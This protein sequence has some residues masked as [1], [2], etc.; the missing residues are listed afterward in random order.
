MQTISE[1]NAFQCNSCQFKQ[2]ALCAVLVC[3]LVFFHSDTRAH[4]EDEKV[5]F[6]ATTGQDLKRCNNR[7]R[8]C[9]SISYAAQ[10][11]NKGDKIL[12]AG[13]SY[14]ITSAEE[15]VYLVSDLQPVYGGYSAID[16]YQSQAPDKFVTSISGVPLAYA[17][18]LYKRGFSVIQDTKGAAQ[19]H[20][21]KLTS[22]ITGKLDAIARMQSVQ[23]ATDC[24]DGSSAGFA[25]K[26]IAL[27]GRLPLSSLPTSSGAANDIWGHV[28]LNDMREYA[29]IGLQRGVA[30]IDVSAPE[31]PVVVGSISGQA[32]T[33]RDIK[34]LQY[35]DAEQQR[36][37]AY[38]YSGGDSVTEG[39][40]IIDLG[41]LP[42]SIR[43]IT[44]SSQDRAS[45][46]IYISGVDYTT[47]TALKDQI[48][49]LHVA[50]SPNFG[51]SWRTFDISNP[52]IPS[53]AYRNSAASR[54]DYTHDASS[55]LIT[56][57]RA[58]RD[59]VLPNASS[60]NVMLDFNEQEVRLWQHNDDQQAVELSR[61]TYPNL[62]YVHSG[63][64]SENKQFIFVHDELDERQHAINTSLNIFDISDLK[65]PQL[66]AT[67]VGPTRA[68]DH[69][70]YVKGNKY[71]ISN[72][73]RGVTILDIGNAT[74][75]R[76][77]GYFDTFGTSDNAS[78]NGV[79]GVYPFLP[80]G[81]I[82]ASDIQGGL[83]ILRDDT[84]GVTDDAVGFASTQVQVEEN[85][86]LSVEVIKQG[87]GSQSVDY[88]IL[89]PSANEQDI[90]VANV[91]ANDKGT[92]TWPANNTKSQFI[93][94][95]AMADTLDEP[96]ELFVVVLN[97]ATNGSIMNS[98]SSA[99]VTIEGTLIN[100]GRIS[101][102]DSDIS[103][104]ETQ[105]T[106]NVTV[107]RRGGSTQALSVNF[108]LVAGSAESTADFSLANGTSGGELTWADSDSSSRLI[109]VLINNDDL[110]ESNEI[111]SIELSAADDSVLGTTQR[112]NVVIRDD[113]SNQTPSVNAGSDIQVN[114]R[115]TIVLREA[116]ASDVDD[117]LRLQWTQLDGT[118]VTL[119]N[120]T[121]LTPTFVAPTSAG[122]FSLQL[123]VTDDFGV[124]ASDII[125]VTVI[126][127]P[128]V[129]TPAPTVNSGGGSMSIL[130]LAWLL[131][132]G[133]RRRHRLPF[134]I[135]INKVYSKGLPR[136]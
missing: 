112:L 29:I 89:Y 1:N 114:T 38:V 45:H 43:L 88:Q 8:P 66:V 95:A 36:F 78:F 63:W 42:N 27:L 134:V 46:N 24:V 99:F 64:W 123:R 106:L 12:L 105:G 20:S 50:G 115:Q 92:L 11:A 22:S 41:D 35:Y 68:T 51:G 59:C 102:D 83:Y 10:Q 131:L 84:L 4:S 111:F 19:A 48:P 23:V 2:L 133:V 3:T 107:R 61:V 132:I 101:F 127:A 57:Q 118:A 100:T 52:E 15:L 49:L 67:W 16:N 53:A 13:G 58:S 21:Q 130:L 60:C 103:I 34:V 73:E 98:K 116:T 129:N 79:W 128:V 37:Q 122:T 62:E 124:S 28:D 55:L 91:D 5:R 135:L 39:L 65:A 126:A 26:N 108:N 7:F 96:N 93:E 40:S 47:N 33:W 86:T 77:I 113:E 76:E 31:S 56:D 44:R 81:I 82:L 109:A 136:Y 25:C 80:S 120:A 121:S 17:Q 14:A 54:N 71:Y 75:P 6:V 32:T 125:I 97:N 110:T 18:A 72:Y 9:K 94:I 69:N 90:S 85:T 70:G 117:N 119:N 104:L 74:A 30:V 87:A